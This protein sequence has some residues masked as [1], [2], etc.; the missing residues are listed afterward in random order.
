MKK[1]ISS[2]AARRRVNDMEFAKYHSYYAARNREAAAKAQA[3][4][5]YEADRNY[6]REE[7]SKQRTMELVNSMP[8]ISFSA[9]LKLSIVISL[10]FSVVIELFNLNDASFLLNLAA[11][12]VIT[13]GY[14]GL[15]QLLK[16]LK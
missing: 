1:G 16:R 6:R 13:F 15:V 2:E 9:L 4:A 5:F 3:E 7:E 14:L 8:R 10:L 11:F 12:F